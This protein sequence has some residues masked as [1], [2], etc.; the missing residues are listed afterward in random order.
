[1]Q[2]LVIVFKHKLRTPGRRRTRHVQCN[3]RVACGTQDAAEERR[4]VEAE[5]GRGGWRKPP[6]RGS[7]GAR[8]AMTPTALPALGGHRRGCRE[9]TASPWKSEAGS[10]RFLAHVGWTQTQSVELVSATTSPQGWPLFAAHE[11]HICLWL[12]L[13]VSFHFP[14]VANIPF[15]QRNASL[16][17]RGP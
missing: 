12:A 8:S 5:L 6:P 3:P 10:C 11:S 2:P 9:H 17:H 4:L 14:Q 15:L 1:M 16:I 7:P 13:L